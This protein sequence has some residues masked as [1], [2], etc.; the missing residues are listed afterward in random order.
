LLVHSEREQ[1]A[2]RIERL[3]IGLSGAMRPTPQEICA[4]AEDVVREAGFFLA[5]G[6]TGLNGEQLGTLARYGF[7]RPKEI[8]L[9]LAAKLSLPQVRSLWFVWILL[10][11]QGRVKTYWDVLSWGRSCGAFPPKRVQSQ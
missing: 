9:D 1:Q 2:L 11:G 6:L 5:L 3:S 10:F 8:R 7:R 4:M